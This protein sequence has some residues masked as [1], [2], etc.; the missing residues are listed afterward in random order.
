MAS[1]FKLAV[2]KEFQAHVKLGFQEYKYG[3]SRHY[4]T[5][6]HEGLQ[7]ERI[8]SG[9]NKQQLQQKLDELL[10][11]WDRKF[12]AQQAREAKQ[13]GIESALDLTLAAEAKLHQMKTIL[14]HTLD[15]NDELDWGR[16]KNNT[17]YKVQKFTE[18]KPE[19]PKLDAKPSLRKPPKPTIPVY[20]SPEVGLMQRLLGKKASIL[21]ESMMAHR[22]KTK[23]IQ[24][25]YDVKVAAWEEKKADQTNRWQKKKEL[26]E[27]AYAEQISEWSKK[28]ADWDR[29]QVQEKNKFNEAKKARNH[30][31]TTLMAAW[32]D[33]ATEAIQTHAEL[34]LESS[35][36]PDWFDASH[37]ILYDADTKLL[38]VQLMLPNAEVVKVPK[39]VR[40]VQTTGELKE[41]LIS[42]KEQRELY[43]SLCYQVAIRTVHELFEADTHN[44]INSVLFNGAVQYVDPATGSEK[45]SVIMSGL[46]DKKPFLEVNLEKVDP[47]SCFKSFNGVAATSLIGMAP[48]P[49]VIQMNTEDR[50]FIDSREVSMESVTATN[51]AAMDWDDFEH[52]VREVFEK[53]FKSRGGEVRVTQSS[54][55]GGVDAIAFD[56]DPISGGK[57]VIQAKRYTN[58]VGVSAVRDLYGTTMNEGASKGILVTTSNYGPDA[59]KFAADKPITL[60]NGGNLLH[61]L[62]KQGVTA[63]IDLK[64]ARRELGLDKS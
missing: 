37:V 29:D 49:P 51:L 24:D 30:D 56:P 15:V 9:Q 16:L 38:K 34:V 36:Y 46:F 33:G 55:D 28:K 53:E 2:P 6:T 59:Y 35:T 17:T 61:L 1:V 48:V 27:L 12:K 7:L 19:P 44:H 43:D 11:S 50:R 47:K 18:L 39:Q 60:L 22:Q 3:T 23:S 31:V 14:E 13:Q 58:T 32:K 5:V 64:A 42:A 26:A 21:E 10:R 25:Q 63:R 62:S 54:S 45:T 52:L 41:T 57:I 20:R 40:F 8:I 4:Q